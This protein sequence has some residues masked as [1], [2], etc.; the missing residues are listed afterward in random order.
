M[1]FGKGVIAIKNKSDL[2]LFANALN[3]HSQDGS[4]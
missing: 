3:A 4:Q 2:K 1:V